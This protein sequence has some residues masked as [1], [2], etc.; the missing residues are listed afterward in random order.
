MSNDLPFETVGMTA[1]DVLTLE[2]TYVELKEKFNVNLPSSTDF[3]I[4]DFDILK[5]DP[6]ITTCA[7]LSIPNGT[8][9]CYLLFAR[10]HIY[11]RYARSGEI[12]D[13]YRYKVFGV[14]VSKK[15]YGR[16][17]V[18]RETFADKLIRL[19]HPF[20][21][22]FKDDK[23]FNNK[24]YVVSNDEEKALFSMSWNLRSAIM[25]INDERMVIEITGSTLLFGNNNWLDKEEIMHLAGNLLK[26]AS[27]C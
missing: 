16:V 27:C 17:L 1:A 24:W 12:I 18:R 23:A 21:L 7:I 9:N 13:Y 3:Q 15:D 4:T 5:N 26:I 20:E 25:D 11:D 14:T 6:D 8:G 10:V 19:I 22:D 2:D